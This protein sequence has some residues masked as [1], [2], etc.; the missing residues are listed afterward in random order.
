MTAVA[1]NALTARGPR[2]QTLNNPLKI[3]NDLDP[4]VRWMLICIF[5]AFAV[6]AIISCCLCGLR[7]RK[8]KSVSLDDVAT[9]IAMT[10]KDGHRHVPQTT[11]GE[12]ELEEIDLD[13]LDE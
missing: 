7:R 5:A 2:G 8:R 9:H 4:L 12:L 3:W 11:C 10:T 6:L 1:S 13:N